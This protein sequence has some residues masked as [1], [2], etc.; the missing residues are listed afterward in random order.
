MNIDVQPRL[1][2]MLLA[3]KLVSNQDIQ[4]AL[5]FQQHFGGRLGAILVRMGAISEDSLLEI[6]AKQLDLPIIHNNNIPFD[7]QF[8]LQQIESSHIEKDW[9]LDQEVVIW[10][11]TDNNIN[12]I[13]RNPLDSNL[14][15]VF[16]HLFANLNI[17]WYLA[18]NQDLDRVLDLLAKTKTNTDGEYI[19][20]INTLREL[21]EGAPV[22]EFVNNMFS[23]AI[24]KRAS[25]VHIEPEE[26]TFYV[27]YRIDGVL[28]EHLN[29]PK[30]RF[31]PIASRIK[32]IS[33]LDIAERRL[34][35]DGRLNIRVSGQDLDI[36]VSC[37][38]AV[39]G[40]SIVMRLLP[41]ERQSSRLQ[42]L[43]FAP[44][45]LTMFNNWISQPHGIIL[46]TGPTGSGKSTTLYAALD[47]VNNRT[48]KIITVEDPVEYQLRGI[49]QVQAHSGIGLNFAAALRSILRQDPDIVMIGEIRDLETAEIAIQA[50]LTGH[51]VLS[52]LHTNDAISA[53]TR[54]VDMGIEAFLVATSVKAVQ[55]Q[56]LVR[57]LCPHCATVDQPLAE[58]QARTKKILP[59]TLDINSKWQKAVGC[60]ECQGSGYMG[61]IGIYELIEI[62]PQLQ[63]LILQR[64][65]IS[66]LR[67]LAAESGFRTLR[68]DGWIKAYQGITSVEEVL[69]ITSEH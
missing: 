48:Q 44:D 39:H 27:R 46:V 41:K 59:P 29:L 42:Q 2:E 63:N 31:N 6:L 18:R 56:R 51:L 34:P 36:R 38:P 49:T 61:R 45:H 47:A 5:D 12:C 53:F 17:I 24:D 32:L 26:H 60:H 14:H 19:D 50:S 1:G 67:Q 9:W 10:Q 40:E 13:A 4:R 20:D 11:D 68:E 23:Q 30:E 15:Q 57:R 37:L 25:D 64:A 7:G 58:I 55:A 62:S 21:A 8:L 28:Y 66:E 22:V 16:E 33:G 52:T 3:A 43:G 65:S 54:L 69:R 35:Q